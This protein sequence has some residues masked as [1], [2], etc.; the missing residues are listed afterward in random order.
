MLRAVEDVM[1]G[2]ANAA[3]GSYE[4]AAEIEE[5][6]LAGVRSPEAEFT[7][8]EWPDGLARWSSDAREPN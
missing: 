5:K 6:P 2:L 1:C 3:V 4:T 7:I 8:G